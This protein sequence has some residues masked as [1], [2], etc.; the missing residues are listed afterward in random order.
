LEHISGLAK[1][2][3]VVGCFIFAKGSSVNN[4]ANQTDLANLIDYKTP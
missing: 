2:A 4:A 1:P 3:V